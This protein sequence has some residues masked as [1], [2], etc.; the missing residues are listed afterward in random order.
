MHET[1]LAA[2]VGGSLLSDAEAELQREL[3]LL[4]R[5]ALNLLPA[6]QRLL[7][8]VPPVHLVDTI[9]KCTVL[10]SK[11]SALSLPLPLL[12]VALSGLCRAKE[13]MRLLTVDCT[14]GNLEVLLSIILYHHPDPLQR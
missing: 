9:A 5:T 14:L 3:T 1:Y 13:D 12:P 6:L 2:L 7:D 11:V 8:M 4:L 10:L